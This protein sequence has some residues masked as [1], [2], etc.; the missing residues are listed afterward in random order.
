MA[1]ALGLLVDGHIAV[2]GAPVP[3]VVGPV[4]APATATAGAARW[5]SVP[6]DADATVDAA[7]APPAGTSS[8]L[9]ISRDPVRDVLL[10]VDL[11]AT[12]PSSRTVL[13][14]HPRSALAA[15]T[16]VDLEVGWMSGTAWDE[17]T[18]TAATAPPQDGAG[19]TVHGVVD[20]SGWLEVDL[21]GVVGGG[22]PV[23]LQLRAVGE[24][25]VV[26]ARESGR[27]PVVVAAMGTA[28]PR[29][30]PVRVWAVG[31]A[32]CRGAEPVGPE[33]CHQWAVSNLVAADATTEAL[34]ALGDLQ[35]PGGG[36]ADFLSGYAPSY[37]RMS[38]ITW[39]TR[40]NHEYLTRDAAGYDA[41]FGSR[42]HPGEGT[43]YSV[44]IGVSWHVVVLDSN[45]V[46]VGCES[47][48]AQER[49]LRA[50]LAASTRPCTIGVWHHP[51]FSSGGHRGVDDAVRPLWQALADDGAEI[52]LNGHDHVYERFHRQTVDGIAD[53]SGIR[54]FVVGTGGRSL[55]DFGAPLATSAV[56]RSVFG[57]LRLDLSVAGY[58]WAFVDEHGTIVD[59][60]TGECS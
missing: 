21:T 46:E 47:G 29:D 9:E 34:L 58:S 39:P 28:P 12:W 56:R 55:Y 16:V 52:V 23:T 14:L 48:S 31:D 25:L 22:A 59:S 5:L 13:R 1:A 54:E 6:V 57:A 10:R 36:I 42:A 37:G 60:G 33:A 53:P 45:C 17:A 43:W 19:R 38:D 20:R 24:P 8:T 41:Y 4:S 35:Y 27:G 11:T 44:D 50:D 30:G 7:L 18:V 15:D 32:A 49:W 51:R 3:E 26:D 2:T 40:G